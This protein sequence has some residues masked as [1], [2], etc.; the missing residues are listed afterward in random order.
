MSLPG[1]SSHSHS[2][3]QIN[4]LTT[5][6]AGE[7]KSSAVDTNV[8]F[9][10]NEAKQSLMTLFSQVKD[11]FVSLFSKSTG[12][13]SSI[14]KEEK[15][16]FDFEVSSASVNSL[17][18]KAA[19]NSKAARSKTMLARF[20]D[21]KTVLDDINK[22][23]LPDK[24]VEIGDIPTKMGKKGDLGGKRQVVIDAL[25]QLK[26][27]NEEGFN[28]LAE[29]Y[30]C[31]PDISAKKLGK[32]I[33]ASMEA[34][35]L[36][37]GPIVTK[38]KGFKIGGQEMTDVQTP[39]NASCTVKCGDTT[40]G[41]PGDRF[42]TGVGCKTN[43]SEG[44]RI[45]NG[46]LS[47]LVIDGKVVSSSVRHAVISSLE[48]T[49][50][51][52]IL[53]GEKTQSIAEAISE[54]SD[55]GKALLQKAFPKDSEAK[56]ETKLAILKKEGSSK[57]KEGLMNNMA[58]SISNQNKATDAVRLQ[59][60]NQLQNM[61][62]DDQEAILSG[63][64]QMDIKM[65]SLSLLTPYGHEKDM[66]AQQVQAMKDISGAGAITLNINGVDTPINVNV[67]QAC[68]NFG[69]NEGSDI[70]RGTEEALNVPSF[71]NFATMVKESLKNISENG[72]DDQKLK[73]SENKD[74]IIKLMEDLTTRMPGFGTAEDPFD[75]PVKMAILSDLAGMGPMFNCKSGKDRTGQ[76]DVQ[77]KAVRAILETQIKSKSVIDLNAISIDKMKAHT[78]EL[79]TFQ[80]TMRTMAQETSS[81]EIQAENTG[82]QGFKTNSK[83]LETGG[84]WKTIKNTVLHS[85]ST[86]A[87][88]YR[89]TD[90]Q[91]MIKFGLNKPQLFNLIY[92]DS[93]KTDS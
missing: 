65:V 71:E 9:D 17:D 79:E 54:S 40:V 45:G 63:E 55:N 23:L 21:A 60:M 89:D 49:S 75:I 16:N 29:K 91:N 93:G 38:V 33:L 6:G 19:S 43:Q 24:Q 27:Q 10:G 46:N 22:L 5:K 44:S 31:K 64:K 68:F 62:P 12:I 86:A 82:L 66:L 76:M 28:K 78:P 41:L 80:S 34:K 15:N 90:A 36:N 85:L 88:V 50:T 1:L 26:S 37:D 72:T 8:R 18:K 73:L 67:Q 39:A 32:H 61:S 81:K 57:A 52:P 14:I 74:C 69:V 42:E 25:K 35:A 4:S 51:T 77:I 13:E 30:K 3:I 2:H 84:L 47:N 7:S 58:Q 59:M 87:G 70:A 53:I 92:V 48:V 20:N 11:A 83:L 56:I